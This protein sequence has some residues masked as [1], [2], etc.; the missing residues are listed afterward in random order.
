MSAAPVTEQSL[1][2]MRQVGD[3]LADAAI[4]EAFEVGAVRRVNELIAGLKHNGD[5][6]PAD[7]PPLL[8]QFFVDTARLPEWADVAAIDRGDQLWG[9]YASHMGT[10]LFCYSLPVCYGWAKG[11]QVLYRTTRLHAQATRRVMETCQ[12][13]QDVNA[14][15]GLLTP[16]GYGLRSA[17]KVRLLHATIRHFLQTS[18]DWDSATNGVAINQEDLAATMCSFAVCIPQGLVKLG[19]DLQAADRDDC[20][21]VW[22]VVGHVMGVDPALMPASFDEGVVL[23]DSVCR[24]QWAASEAGRVLTA[25]LVQSMREALGPAL[26]GA[27]PSLIRHFC[28]DQLADMLA[29]DPADWTALMAPITTTTSLLYGKLG[30]HSELVRAVSSK[31]GEVMIDAALRAAHRGNRYDWTIPESEAQHSSG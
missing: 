14:A 3:P 12:M 11:A 8:R 31:V 19:V 6:V 15:G 1:E 30:D 18:T 5:E 26:H 25:A 27:P 2:S 17:Q 13:L 4:A 21:H 23:M 24:H 29:V 9:R 28:G 10:I 20:F 7:L 16:A 22:S